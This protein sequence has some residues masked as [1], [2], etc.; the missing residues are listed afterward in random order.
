MCVSLVNY[1]SIDITFCGDWAGNSYATSG[2]PGT[3]PDRLKD[4]A[5]FDVCLLTVHCDAVLT[6]SHM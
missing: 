2:C 5:N 1:C 6:Y 3:C 4:P